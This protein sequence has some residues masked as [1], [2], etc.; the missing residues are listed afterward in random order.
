MKIYSR[1]IKAVAI[2]AVLLLS[3]VS[4][5]ACNPKIANTTLE[6]QEDG[7][8]IT[9]T[10]YTDRTTVTEVAIPETVE[11]KPVV[12]LQS[13]AIANSETLKKVSIPKTVTEI[14]EWAFSNNSNLEYIDVADDN[15]NYTDIN[16]VL[17]TKDCKT[18]LYMPE[19]SKE[20]FISIADNGD[21]NTKPYIV[22]PTT[23]R[24]AGWAFYKN[25]YIAD[26]VLSST[27]KTIGEMAFFKCYN[28]TKINLEDTQL[29]LLTFKAFAFC[30]NLTDIHI[31][32]TIKSIESHVFLD[33][34][35]MENF[36]IDSN[37]N[38]V[39]LGE[40][41]YPTENGKEITTHNGQKISSFSELVVWKG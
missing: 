17:Y 1:L 26:I 2:V 7:G 30:Q 4:L 34:Y 40:R 22:M 33:C 18:L 39:S 10:A 31:P 41:W 12:K 3:A 20:Y 24:I 35:K 5:I 36:V 32:S 28:L 14:E 38:A 16:G 6:Y 9:I 37:K 8:K 13:F 23:E 27:L 25:D 21:I 29:E 11:G 19:K 15:P